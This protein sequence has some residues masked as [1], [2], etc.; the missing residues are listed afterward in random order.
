MV[1]SRKNLAVFNRAG[2]FPRY[3]QRITDGSMLMIDDSPTESSKVH[4]LVNAIFNWTEDND[5]KMNISKCKEM[6][7][8]FARVRQE[9]LPL[10]I[11]EVVMEREKSARILGLTVQDNLK[12]N[13][14]VNHI[15]KKASKRLYMLGVLKR[16]NADTNTLLTVY[17]TIITPVLEYAC[18]VWHCN[19]TEY[20]YLFVS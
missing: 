11:K 20:L 3:D 4:E 7:F 5:V 13:E 12:W 14:H 16:S 2:F 18:E 17:K 10:T 15:V 19:I 6:I 1:E 8:D 9:F